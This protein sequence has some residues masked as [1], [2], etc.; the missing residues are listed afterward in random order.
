MK[1]ILIPTDFS[2]QSLF[3]ITSATTLLERMA[4]ELTILHV[5]TGIEDPDEKQKNLAK[6]HAL[7]ELKGV[8]FHFKQVNGKTIQTILEEPAD[9]IVM[10]SKGAKG[11]NSFFVGTHTEKVAKH[12]KCPVFVLKS[13]TDLAHFD[14]I[15]F[16]TSM[17]RDDEDILDDLKELQKM[18]DA[19][20]HLI[21][22][23]D[24]SLVKKTEVEKRLKKYG[25]VHALSNFTVSAR[26]GIDE[27]YVIL[28]FSDE[29]NADLIALATHDRRGLSK[30]FG[31]YISGDVIN[32]N[33]RPLWVKAL[34][35][36]Y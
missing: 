33:P 10:G 17:K 32:T 23:F 13:H 27:S 24:D 25:E 28:A 36:D 34:K 16:P 15:V 6:I 30:L 12:A 1:R 2:E 7:E 22:A 3:A 11:F 8:P 5:I 26:S 4:A 35:S 31:G 20:L 18:F 29:I 9:I 19:K 21:K 14:N